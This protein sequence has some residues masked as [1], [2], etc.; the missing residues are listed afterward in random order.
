MKTAA[1][2]LLSGTI[3]ATAAGPAL[4]QSLT[5][6]DCGALTKQANGTYLVT[7]DTSIKDV[8]NN[9]VSIDKGTV[10]GSDTITINGYSGLDMIDKKCAAAPVRADATPPTPAQSAPAPAAP[11]AVPTPPPLPAA[12]QFFYDA[13]GQPA[14]PIG[15][16]DLQAKIAAGAIGPATLVWKGGMPNWVAAKDVPELSGSF[17]P[18]AGQAAAAPFDMQGYFTG[19]WETDGPGPA[20]TQGPARMILSLGGNGS[21]QGN[22]NVTLV[23]GTNASI[24]VTGSWTVAAVSDKIANLTLNLLV[25]GNNGPP[26]PLNSTASLEIVD[27]NTVHDTAQGTV[28]RRVGM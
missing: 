19:T 17:A 22:Y 2:I 3:I 15:L 11:S 7:K 16:A 5:E 9:T 14:G 4:A 12:A 10:I 8:S 18:A 13:G 28:S 27:P 20:G 25:H 1:L 23:G 26:T 6:V 21:V 24:P